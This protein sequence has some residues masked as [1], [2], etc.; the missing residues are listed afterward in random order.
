M[1]EIPTSLPKWAQLFT[2]VSVGISAI[3]YLENVQRKMEHLEEELMTLADEERLRDLSWAAADE[4]EF[5]V[6][7]HTL[8]RIIDRVDEIHNTIEN[9]SVL[10]DVID[11]QVNTL[12][13]Q[14]VDTSYKLG[15][16]VGM[17]TTKD[18]LP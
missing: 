18:S 1:F 5:T 13:A 7:N 15:L 10:L 9:H 16:I 8:D 6:Q 12:A 11:Q 3:L 4:N 17:T 14:H 2:V